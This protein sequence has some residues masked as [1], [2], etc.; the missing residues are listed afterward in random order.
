MPRVIAYIVIAVVTWQFCLWLRT[1][2]PVP[3]PEKKREAISRIIIGD[4]DGR[5]RTYWAK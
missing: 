3:A 1:P 2:E 5:D 4:G